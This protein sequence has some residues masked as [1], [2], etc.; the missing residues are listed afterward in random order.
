MQGNASEAE[1]SPQIQV[2]LAK[3]NDLYVELGQDFFTT[4]Q[5]R[6]VGLEYIEN[7]I[8][9]LNAIKKT[10]ICLKPSINS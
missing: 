3:L 10:S 9:R 8:R 6:T 5:M 2:R 1:D 4:D 7:T